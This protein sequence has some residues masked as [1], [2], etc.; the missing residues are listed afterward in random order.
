[1]FFLLLHHSTHWTMQ[2]ELS[3]Q[4]SRNSP[5]NQQLSRN[6][7]SC[8]PCNTRYLHTL[9]ISPPTNHACCAAKIVRPRPTNLLCLFSWLQYTFCL[10]WVVLSHVLFI[11]DHLIISLNYFGLLFC[12]SCLPLV[13]LLHVLFTFGRFIVYHMFLHVFFYFHMHVCLLFLLHLITFLCLIHSHHCMFCLLHCIL[14]YFIVY[15]FIFVYFI[16]CLFTFIYFRL[17]M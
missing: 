1:M 15:L 4:L 3:V 17:H 6:H 2:I 8:F 7:R 11:L 10:L 14:V 5:V 12:I 16:T 9:G 13:V